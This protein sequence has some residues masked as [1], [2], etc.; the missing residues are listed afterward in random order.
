MGLQ[1]LRKKV[2]LLQEADRFIA[3]GNLAVVR[4]VFSETRGVVRQLP[5]FARHG[6]QQAHCGRY[7]AGC[8]RHQKNS[9]STAAA[10]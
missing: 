5:Q 1:A 3:A 6:L 7:G 10:V 4:Q 8:L 9:T 2:E